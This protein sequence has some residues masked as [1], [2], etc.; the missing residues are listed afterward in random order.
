[1]PVVN[2]G[3]LRRTRVDTVL[4]FLHVAFVAPLL[5]GEFGWLA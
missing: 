1:M 3:V 5:L 4:A 2:D